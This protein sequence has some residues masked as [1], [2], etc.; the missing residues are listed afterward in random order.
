VALGATS[1][2]DK[3]ALARIHHPAVGQALDELAVWGDIA[4]CSIIDLEVGYSARGSKEH[5]LLVSQRR[6]LPRAPLTQKTLDRALAV[7]GLLARRGEHR[8]SLPDLIISA[9]AEE[10]GLVVVHYDSDFDTIAR[11]TNQPTQWVVPRGSVP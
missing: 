9:C 10:N 6:L 1:L 11:V 7:Q 5:A 4:T 3:S 8:V 2:V